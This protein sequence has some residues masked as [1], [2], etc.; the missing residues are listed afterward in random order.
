MNY[1]IKIADE[2]SV[3]TQIRHK[4][5]EEFKDLK[6]YEEGHIYTLNGVNVPSVSSIT[7]R[8]EDHFDE[9]AQA[10]AYAQ[11]HGETKEHWLDVWHQNSFKATTL[12]TR[13]HAYGESLGWVKGGHPELIV[14]EILPQYHKEKGWLV[15]IHKKEEAIVKFMDDLPSCYH[16]VLNEARVYSGKNPNKELNP[17][18]QYCG[19][20]DMLY[21]Y[22]GEGDESK[23]GLVI[24]D[25]KTN[26][27]LT[28]EYSRS[29]NKMMYPPF[30]NLYQE[31]LGNYSIQL[32]CYQI[33]LEDIGLKVLGRRL[34]WLKDD[35]TYEKVETP[36]LTKQLRNI[37]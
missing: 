18:E 3:V 25:Y 35:G 20:F 8:F 24:F 15:P 34:I 10:E 33:P 22:D 21:Y 12:G 11:K 26:K 6:F 29:T 31:S 4:I 23:A 13:V 7:H 30:D 9:N 28:K 1:D 36:D 19:T 37:L 2:P 16:L 17:K 27:S 32:S 5:L 14:P